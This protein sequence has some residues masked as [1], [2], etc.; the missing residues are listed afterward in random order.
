M[1]TLN[2]TEEKIIDIMKER[3]FEKDLIV[4]MILSCEKYNCAQDLLDFLC[5]KNDCDDQE[6][7]GLII[8]KSQQAD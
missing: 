8:E 2:E 4:G 3:G 1:S 5:K 6:I 7:L